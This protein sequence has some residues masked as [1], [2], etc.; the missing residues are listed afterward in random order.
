[1]Q[2]YARTSVTHIIYTGYRGP[3]VVFSDITLYS[4]LNVNRRFGESCCL[5]LHGW[6]ISQARN[7]Y[8][9]IR[10]QFGIFFDPEDGSDMFFRDVG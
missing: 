9:A 5:H 8:E 7:Q 1:M 6:R 3:A 10:K 4:P 2:A